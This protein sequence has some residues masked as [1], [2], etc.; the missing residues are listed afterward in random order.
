MVGF[1]EREIKYTGAET[2][3]IRL[4]ESVSMLHDVILTGYLKQKK[5]DITGAI[6]SILNRDFKDQP[7]S[8]VAQ[9]IQ[10]KLAGILVTTPSGTPGA[11]LLVSIRG[12]NNPLYVVDGVP[13]ISQ[14]NSSLST[15]YNTNGEEQ[16]KG[17]D[18]SS[19]SDINPDD[20]ESIEVL[21]D[22]SSASIYGSRGC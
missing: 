16:G 22:A 20:I 9:S 2:L 7:V 18:I 15:S 5:S 8:N 6:S 3:D 13:M 19:I 1:Q 21:K 10:G 4:E 12:A 14:S 11:G 17:Q